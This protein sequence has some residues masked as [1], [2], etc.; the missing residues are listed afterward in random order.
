MAAGT[1]RPGFSRHARSLVA[2]LVV[3]IILPW[4]ILALEHQGVVFATRSWLVVLGGLVA[5]FGLFLFIASVRLFVLIGAG[6]IMPWDPT[7]KLIVRGPYRY[8]RNP[9]IMGVVAVTFGE[10]LAFGSVWIGVLALVF[11]IGNAVYFPL[12]EERGLERRFGAEYREYKAHVPP[13]IPRITPWSPE[14]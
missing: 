2:P 13:W 14:R 9:M 5:A 4:I 1:E 7:R 11:L 3:W 10:A 8:V 6:T 12:S